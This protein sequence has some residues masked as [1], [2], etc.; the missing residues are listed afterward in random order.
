MAIN[1]EAQNDV[2]KSALY[3]NSVMVIKTKISNVQF[4]RFL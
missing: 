3:L 4:A 2:I 1:N